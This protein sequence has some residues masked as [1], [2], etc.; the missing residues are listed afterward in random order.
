MLNLFTPLSFRARL[1]RVT[2]VDTSGED[3][4]FTRYA[5]F[6]E[7]NDAMALRNGGRK[8]DWD[9]QRQL[10]PAQIDKEQAVLVEVFQYMIG[11][12][13]W[14]GVHM[15]NM[16]LL[17][18]PSNVLV[19][20][21]FDF[22]MA[23]IVDARYSVPDESL[24]IRSVRQRLFRGFCPEQL[25]R[26]RETYEAVFQTFRERKEE[27]YD[28]W[29]NQADLEENRLEDTLEWLDEFY[30]VL[31]DPDEIQDEIFERCVRIGD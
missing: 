11:N 22:D 2:Y 26:P 16:E 1:A 19:T 25:N 3:D 8:L 24:P 15:H 21:P 4:A 7:D 17:R 30:E 14:S 31:E 27:V 9:I 5:I 23:G 28:L 18:L 13:D 29:R 10:H 12:T 6:L 20:V